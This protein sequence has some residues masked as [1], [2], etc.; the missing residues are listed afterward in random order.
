MKIGGLEPFS[1][2][3]SKVIRKGNQFLRSKVIVTP[4][5]NVTAKLQGNT[6]SILGVDGKTQVMRMSSSDK[7]ITP[8]RAAKFFFDTLEGLFDP[9]NDAWR[10]IKKAAEKYGI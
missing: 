4:S 1:G 2:A 9:K 8:Q 10:D 5:G 3:A 6:V 7:Q